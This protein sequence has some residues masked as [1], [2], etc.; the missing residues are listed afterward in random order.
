MR[1][2]ADRVRNPAMI[3]GASI[4]RLQNKPMRT[5]GNYR[6]YE[7]LIMKTGDWKTCP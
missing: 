5:P 3:I 2:V 7:M 6:V 4:K 1:E